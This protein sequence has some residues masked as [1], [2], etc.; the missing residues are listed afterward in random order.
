MAYLWH[1]KYNI[2]ASSQDISGKVRSKAVLRIK[3][4]SWKEKYDSGTIGH[5]FEN[6][7]IMELIQQIIWSAAKPQM[8]HSCWFLFRNFLL[9]LP[10]RKFCG[11]SVFRKLF[12]QG[13]AVIPLNDD[14]AVLDRPAGAAAAL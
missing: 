5:L 3:T 13:L 10:A 6:F 4:L 14:D 11:I 9:T 1:I 8:F 2:W 7:V 12:E